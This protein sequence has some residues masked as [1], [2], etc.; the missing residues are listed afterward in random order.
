[1]FTKVHLTNALSPYMHAT[2]IVFGLTSCLTVFL[3]PFH[4]PIS[5]G[6]FGLCSEFLTLWAGRDLYRTTP[7]VT[8]ELGFCNLVQ[9]TTPFIPR[10]R[11]AFGS[12]TFSNSDPRGMQNSWI[13]S[14]TSNQ[15]IDCI[16]LCSWITNHG[17]GRQCLFQRFN[18]IRLMI[19][20]N[21]IP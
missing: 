9:K 13:H 14:L 17:V 21:Q 5:K 11:T 15:S 10:L 8:R 1:M 12:E 3:W 16:I 6:L 18:L 2:E 4:I 20:L 7:A 19:D